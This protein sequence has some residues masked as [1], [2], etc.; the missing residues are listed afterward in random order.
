MA[1][2]TER[3]AD[4]DRFIALWQQGLQTASLL[5]RLALTG[6]R[7]ERPEGTPWKRHERSESRV[8]TAQRLGN[9][10]TGSPRF[11]SHGTGV[12][13]CCAETFP[14]RCIVARMSASLSSSEASMCSVPFSCLSAE[15]LPCLMRRDNVDLLIPACFAACPSESFMRVHPFRATLMRRRSAMKACSITWMRCNGWT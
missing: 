7:T 11:G 3:N 15:T 6:R 9:R 8:N 1:R 13:D 10:G 12:S 4:E 2:T 14:E 5:D